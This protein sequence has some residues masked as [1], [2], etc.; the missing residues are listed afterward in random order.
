MNRRQT[1]PGINGQWAGAVLAALLLAVVL[2]ASAQG[3]GDLFVFQA[4]DAVHLRWN[5]P[6]GQPFEG[7]VIERRGPDG[8]WQRLNEELVAPVSDTAEIERLLGRQADVLLGFFERDIRQIGTEDWRR[9]AETPE[10]MSLLR[11]L[12]VQQPRV[13]LAT[14]ER[15]SDTDLEPG[16]RFDYRVVMRVDGQS[17]QLATRSG[18]VH[19]RPDQVPV[20]EGLA[21]EP[22]DRRANL[23]WQVDPAQSA[24]GSAIAYRV[25]RGLEPDEPFETVHG[26]PIIPMRIN[27]Q[28]PEFLYVDVGLDNGQPYLY[29]IRAVNLLGFESAASERIEITPRATRAPDAPELTATLLADSVLLEWSA[30]EYDD[31]AG[32]RVYQG[33]DDTEPERVW[34]AAGLA[35]DALMWIAEEWPDG[36]MVRWYVTAVDMAGN[37]SA[38]SNFIELFRPDVTPPAA[39]VNLTATAGSDGILLEWDANEEADLLGYLVQRTTRVDREEQVEG[40]FFAE[41]P[42]PLTEP[43]WLDPVP[44]TSQARYAYRVIA[45]DRAGNESEPSDVVVARMPDIVPPQAPVLTRIEQIDDTIHLAW[46]APPDPDLAGFRVWTYFDDEQAREVAHLD[47]AG[48]T[49]FEHVAQ[50]SDTPVHYTVTAL[51]EAGNESD[52]APSLMIRVLDLAGP[53]APRVEGEREPTRAMLQWSYPGDDERIGYQLLFRADATDQE[54]EFLTELEADQRE[55]TD[56]GLDP[57]HD[58][59]YRL[60]AVD[61]HDRAGPDS[62]PLRLKSPE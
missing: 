41:H 36:V 8:Q 37:E 59:I 4:D 10:Q 40:E 39:P 26:R 46:L 6:L 12:T 16:E 15:F 54:P 18:I 28:L 57:E 52:P 1:S 47:S 32:Y 29:E 44:E 27:D 58:Y 11:L 22:G 60:R 43:R 33:F 50:P 14:G 30:V 5:A 61:R 51:D 13:A 23:A 2:P 25:Y 34:P 55:F 21:G 7:F 38:P 3:D 62:T 31:L 49:E 35:R 24:D 19:G 42:A 20:P 48:A 56:T 17:R 45:V 9:L 53:P